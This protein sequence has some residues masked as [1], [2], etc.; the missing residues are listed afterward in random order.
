MTKKTELEIGGTRLELSN[1]DKVF[2]LEVG[3]TKSQ[4]IGYYVRIVPVLLPHLADRPI[5]LKPS[6]NN[7]G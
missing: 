7:A 4:V 2:Y 1:L 3:F 6:L 5:S